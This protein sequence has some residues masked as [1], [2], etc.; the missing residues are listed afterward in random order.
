MKWSTTKGADFMC[1]HCS[2]LYETEYRHLIMNN[3][4]AA[5][6][7]VCDKE[8]SWW[9]SSSVPSYLLKQHGMHTGASLERRT[10]NDDEVVPKLQRKLD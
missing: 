3:R 4:G 8:M 5:D 9:N 1:P 10:D 7:V 2:A 6:C